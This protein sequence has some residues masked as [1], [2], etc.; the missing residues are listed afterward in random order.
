MTEI[1]ESVASGHS[2]AGSSIARAPSWTPR[3]WVI[4]WTPLLILP[5]VAV[6]AIRHHPAWLLMWALS[7]ALWLGL[8]WATVVDATRAGLRPGFR[9]SLAYMFA[10][11]NTDSLAFLN[12]RERG[13]KPPARE[14]AG[15]LLNTCLGLALLYIGVRLTYPASALLAGWVG[16]IG[17]VLVL[18]FGLF[19][20]L[21]CAWRGAGINATSLMQDPVKATSLAEF[22]G[23]RWNTAF[24]GPA[25]RYMHRPLAA[26]VGATGATLSV[27]LA[28][29]LLH[30]AVISVPAGGG[31]GLPTAYFL[32][33][34]LMLQLEHSRIGRRLGLGQ[35]LRG[36]AFVFLVT[37]GPA[38]MLFHPIF[39]REVILPFLAVIGAFEGR[40]L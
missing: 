32:F 20:L 24:S 39:V 30:E 8:K 26:R 5:G 1:M 36:W 27:F 10:W 23:R 4:A 38:L 37:A 16:M 33:Q 40:M 13:L 17:L 9:R 19:Q 29:G 7:S 28:S 35:G 22:W 11:P 14:W 21:A 15:A 2:I 18:H 6:W 31:Y 25:R 34:A 3:V 12:A